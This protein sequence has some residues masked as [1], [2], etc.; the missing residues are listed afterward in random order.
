[1]PTMVTCSEDPILATTKCRPTHFLTTSLLK[2]LP[3]TESAYEQH[4]RRAVLTCKPNVE[5]CEDY[6]WTVDNGYLIPVQLTRQAWPQHIMH[7]ISSGC[8]RNCSCAKKNIACRP[9][10]L[11]CRSQGSKKCGRAR[12]T[13]AF[14]S[15][16]NSDNDN[17]HHQ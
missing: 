12:Y 1:M 3:P 7:T 5:Q 4:L 13:T 15:R 10:Y 16:S 2:V 6:G 9:V 8:S 17:E 11:G 14:D